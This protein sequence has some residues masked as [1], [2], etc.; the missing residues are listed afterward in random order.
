METSSTT[1]IF[2]R[3]ITVNKMIAIQNLEIN[4]ISFFYWPFLSM[5][6][7]Q[8]MIIQTQKL[9]RMR[10]YF[11]IKVTFSDALLVSNK[12]IQRQR[13]QDT[14]S[15]YYGVALR[16]TRWYR[17]QVLT[18]ASQASFRIWLQVVKL[19]A[20]IFWVHLSTFV[21][22]YAALIVTSIL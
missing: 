10:L 18:S 11:K 6:P 5:A 2:S 7:R 4:L 1:S 21:H 9:D 14:L 12:M 22:R 19:L 15:T 8:Q 13:M 3:A 20:L 17:D 16:D